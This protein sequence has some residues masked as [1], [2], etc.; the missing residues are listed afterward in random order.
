M[1]RPICVGLTQRTDLV[2]EV[3]EILDMTITDIM[4]VIMTELLNYD[5]SLEIKERKLQRS[6][7]QDNVPQRVLANENKYEEMKR[8]Y[9]AQTGLFLNRMNAFQHFL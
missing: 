2:C 6:Y 8:I 9:D 4:A 7:F 5:P 3:T 1:K